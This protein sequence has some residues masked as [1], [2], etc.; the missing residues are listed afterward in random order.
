MKRISGLPFAAVSVVLDP[1]AV[2]EV[3]E[4]GSPIAPRVA[5][6]TD[7]TSDSTPAGSGVLPL[8]PEEPPFPLTTFDAAGVAFD[9]PPVTLI[10]TSVTRANTTRP[11][12]TSA[13]S[14]GCRLRKLLRLVDFCVDVCGAGRDGRSD[15]DGVFDMK[16]LLG[17][18]KRPEWHASRGSMGDDG[19]R[20]RSSGAVVQTTDGSNRE[21][22][23]G[24]NSL[25]SEPR[26]RAWTRD[27]K[28]REAKAA[29]AITATPP[30]AT[31]MAPVSAGVTAAGVLF[32]QSAPAQVIGP[33]G[34]VWAERT[35]IPAGGRIP[36]R[37]AC[38]RKPLSTTAA[39]MTT[40]DQRHRRGIPSI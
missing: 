36:E 20:G 40:K 18:S 1:V 3:D 37:S 9:E 16:V 30:R 28:R 34:T 33:V 11:I 7:V 29:A 13:L 8:E 5:G 12:G 19:R 24:W 2:G 22:C 26:G 38:G 21:N 6:L 32:P 17:R 23:G 31:N 15:P 39:R 27:R 14:I 25:I 35:A 4:L 10:T